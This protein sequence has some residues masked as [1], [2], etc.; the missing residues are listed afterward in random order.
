MEVERSMNESD[1]RSIWPDRLEEARGRIDRVREQDAG[2]RVDRRVVEEHS[3]LGDTK[4]GA[5]QGVRV[6]STGKEAEMRAS[7]AA[8][9]D[10]DPDPDADAGA[11]VDADSATSS[12]SLHASSHVSN[13]SPSRC[14][15]PRVRAGTAMSPSR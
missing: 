4:Y 9:A 2:L 5:P 14:H 3:A 13:G 15:T 7:A 1:V 8:I 11:D 12:W 6:V 10:A